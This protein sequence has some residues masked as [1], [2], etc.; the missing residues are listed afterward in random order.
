MFDLI[1][2]VLEDF[3]INVIKKRS[4]EKA[5]EEYFRNILRE[6]KKGEKHEMCR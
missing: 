3:V 1:N 2:R 5:D 4:Q 6:R